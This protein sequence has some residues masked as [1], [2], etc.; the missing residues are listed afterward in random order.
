MPKGATK[1]ATRSA[2]ALTIFPLMVPVIQWHTHTMH[3]RKHG[4]MRARPPPQVATARVKGAAKLEIPHLEDHVSKIE[5]VGLQTQKKLED[6]R[7][8]A[9]AAN[10]P[11]LH[12]PVNCVTK[13]ACGDRTGVSGCVCVGGGGGERAG[14]VY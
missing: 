1:L 2:T 4:R 5:C 8:A 6:I 9:A 7:A 11:D 12:L 10:V 14:R 13:G 3:C